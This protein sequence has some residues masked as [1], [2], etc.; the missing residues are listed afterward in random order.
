MTELAVAIVG[1]SGRF[2]GARDIGQYWDNL[3]DGVCSIRDFSDSELRAAGVDPAELGRSGYVRALGYLADADRF[4]PEL[5]G[6]SR[7]EAAVLDPQQR[8]MLE[9]VWSALED[10]GYNPLDAPARTG[11][12]AG[13][14]LSDHMIAAFADRRLAADIGAMQVRMLA[15]RE[16]LAPWVSY[17]LGLNGPSVTVQTACSTAL[18]AVHLAVQAL[19]LGEC[20]AALAGGVSVPSVGKH[21][22][23][24][25]EG[26]IYSPDG[27][28]RPFSEHAAGTVGGSGVGAV[29]LRRLDDAL[30][31]GDPVRA[32]IRG[33]A[34][35]ND[36]RAK[37]G[38]TA[39]SPERQAAAIA[40]AWS[41]AGLEPAA[42]QYLEMHGTGTKLGDRVEAAAVRMAR[43]ARGGS[44][45]I[46][47]VKSNIGHLDAAAGVAGLIKVV[48]M[49]GHATIAPTVN[50]PRPAPDLAQDADF[51]RL[52]TETAPWTAAGGAPR[53]AGVTAAGIGGT[54]VHVV[55]EEAPAAAPAPGSVAGPAPGGTELLPVSARTTAQLG[56]AARRL[57]AA[58]RRPESPALGA[59]ARTLRTGRAS[60]TCR[61]YV[62]AAT[63]SGAAAALDAL[64]DGRPADPGPAGDDGLRRLGEAWVNGGDVTWPAP[65]RAVRRVHLPTYP[66]AGESYG[67]L[68]LAG[69][70]VRPAQ[71]GT[72]PPGRLEARE[73]Q[74]GAP[75]IEAAVSG[76]LLSS[77]EL[78]TA[79][80]LGRTYFAAGG[81]SLGA[82]HLIGRLYDDFGV[83]IPIE[84]FFEPLTLGQLAAR[85]AAAS[86]AELLESVLDQI[87][88]GS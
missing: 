38:F 88:A 23:V 54:N 52:A 65:D 59:V 84:L 18:T 13:A 50:V 83:D 81:D 46:G 12:Y 31:D 33:T 11:V 19:Q 5:F 75:D 53:L 37:V 66:F 43:G 77:L 44:C 58:L 21:G 48:L 71:E 72:P 42:A 70:E 10:A 15:D 69:L 85:I 63:A 76:M 87:D 36:G 20:D 30:A 39:P 41:V 57:A 86:G 61:G 60:L 74:E 68:S 62:L 80:D 64:A 26:G 1:M 34:V 24:Y 17:R 51:L 25:S 3:R 22:Y 82:V 40:E 78:T 49:L 7:A 67:A 6:F 4:E 9:A 45:L 14:S 27:R 28:C 2:P 35:T 56:G 8:L 29:V 47:S 73:E 79:E 55:V 32:V 16:F